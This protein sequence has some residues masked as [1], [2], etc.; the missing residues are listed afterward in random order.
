MRRGG[1]RYLDGGLIDNVPIRALPA[2]ARER[3]AK[4]VCVISHDLE[5]PSRPV[6]DES[7]AQVLYLA[8]SRTLPIRVWDYT[9]PPRARATFEIGRRDGADARA[10]LSAFMAD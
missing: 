2:P 7:G 8:A 3:G 10:R 4:I 5:V 6:I 9:S 1:R